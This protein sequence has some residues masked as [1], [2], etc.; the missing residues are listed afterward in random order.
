MNTAALDMKYTIVSYGSP[1]WSLGMA[2][3]TAIGKHY[4]L[5][6][7]GFGGSSDS[8]VV[9]TQ[10][11]IEATFS[12]MSA[13]L[14]R[15]TLVHDV[16]YIE[17]G[18]TSSA[19]MLVIADEVISMTRFLTEG[20][21]INKETLALD[22]IGRAE[23]GSGFIADKHTY[24]NFRTAQ[25]LPDIIDRNVH[26][27]WQ[28]KGSKDMFTRANE[29]VRKILAEHTVAPLPQEAEDVFAEILA[30]RTEK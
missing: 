17:Y 5:P 10:A 13:F 12:I 11:G 25:W 30:E 29:R 27:S 1:E 16:A 3:W 20:I 6:V 9:D 28:E 14:A 18:S 22:A 19:E 7:W 21:P 15:T 2:G 26:D 4:N 8:K 24:K 23:P